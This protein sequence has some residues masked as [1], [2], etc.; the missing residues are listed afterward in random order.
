MT[1]Q[2]KISKITSCHVAKRYLVLCGGLGDA[3]FSLTAIDQNSDL[4]LIVNPAIKEL[5]IALK[6]KRDA[7]TINV[8]FGRTSYFGKICEVIKFYC[9]MI[10]IGKGIYF[11]PSFRNLLSLFGCRVRNFNSSQRKRNRRDA[12]KDLLN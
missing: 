9:Y 7:Y 1:N 11:V 5:L 2:N 10:K 3:V 12:I 8:S 6:V 4:I